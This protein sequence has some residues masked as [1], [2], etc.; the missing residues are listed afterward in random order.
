MKTL[1]IDGN[2]LVHRTFWVTKHRVDSYDPVLGDNIENLH[3]YFTLNA[4]N[5]YVSMFKPTKIYVAWDEKPD[6]EANIRKETLSEYK[7]NRSSDVSPHQNNEIIKHFLE[8][9][10]IQSIFPRELEADDVIAYICNETAGQKVIISVDKDFMQ[11]V[12]EN[13]TLFDPIRKKEFN[14]NNFEE[15][16]GYSTIKDWMTAKCL[17][18]DKSDNV[19]GIPKFGKV[20]VKKFLDGYI[21]LNESE[22]AI[23]ERNMSLFNLQKYNSMERESLYYKVQLDNPVK[24]NW[25]DFVSECTDRSFHNILK[26]KESWYSLFFMQQKL[27]SLFT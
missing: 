10:G 23:F 9:L 19:S 24:G 11:L 12:N 13:V 5:S 3:V 4:I 27:S 1:I 25:K 8:L 21:T 2:N 17:M 26:K 16:T 6:Y 20:K 14:N 7:G 18:G 22:E 15:S